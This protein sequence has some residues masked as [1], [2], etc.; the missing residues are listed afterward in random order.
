MR[1]SVKL[2]L[3]LGVLAVICMAAFAVSRHEEKKEQIKSSGEVILQIPTDTVTA[4]SWENENGS[5]SFTKEESWIYDADTAFPVDAS[6]METMLE[7][8][9]QLTAAFVIEAVE[10]YEQYG[11]D[12]PICTITI[13]SGE[14]NTTV[15][16]GDFS[17]MDEQRY[18]SLGDG[19]AYLLA[20]DPLEEFDA[21]LRDM[22]CDDVLPEYER[23]EKITFSGKENY[24]IEYEEAGKSICADDVYFADG[25]P[26]DT[27]NVTEYLKQLK[28]V[29]LN[30]YVSYHVTEEELETFGLQ[31]P[32]LS[33]C[34]D[35]T[36]T[37]EDE[38]IDS[39]T[40]LLHFGRNAE[41]L[42]AYEEALER[43][44][45]ELPDV[46]CYVR[47]GDSQIV[48]EIPQKTYDTLTDVGY[49]VLRHSELFTADFANVTE[50]EVSLEGETYRFAYEIA[51]TEEATAEGV[52]MYAETEMDISDI[53]T[54]LSSITA[55]RFTDEAADAQEE[56]SLILHLNQ[57]DFPTVTL[58]LYR[59]DG[60]SCLAA[61]D[62]TPVAF[63]SRSQV[64]ELIEA[65]HE[66]VL[67]G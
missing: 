40:M 27:Q 57:K 46:T 64:V 36:T 26:L 11:L 45:A 55:E 33:V 44:D 21:V 20:H 32:E 23:A 1:K 28:A 31:T 49:D 35:Y 67:N 61:V 51:E 42:A 13:S 38:T 14:E 58:T 37:E 62:G 52:W 10:D 66:V 30:S 5:F 12:E 48:Y 19:N 9:E 60:T 53:R 65:V 54:A 63:V 59:H 3:L 25:K 22:I 8:F 29:P 24:A 15:T 2:Y 4:L 47:V 50:I 18:A 7:Q 56:I 41:E 16:L 43:E 39:G 34:V 17:K 6:K